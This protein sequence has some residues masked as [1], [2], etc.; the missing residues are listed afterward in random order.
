MAL[1]SQLRKLA[2]KHAIHACFLA[3]GKNDDEAFAAWFIPPADGKPS[4]KLRARDVVSHHLPGVIIRADLL[5][6][7]Y[8]YLCEIFHEAFRAK[9]TEFAQQYAMT[10]PSR[11]FEELSALTKRLIGFTA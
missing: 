10:G 4:L 3:S 7:S 1:Q 11:S 5:D 6:K 2:L 9:E 8:E